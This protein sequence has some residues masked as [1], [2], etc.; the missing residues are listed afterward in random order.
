M[1]SGALFIQQ[2]VGWNLY[3]S[4]LFLLGITALCTVSG[5]DFPVHLL[6]S[7]YGNAFDEKYVSPLKKK[8]P[9]YHPF[10]KIFRRSRALFLF[11]VYGITAWPA[12]VDSIIP[13]HSI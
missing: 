11:F 6:C 4:I 1:Y 12:L 2:S 3:L 13:H 5:M 7:S 10:S 8:A 9:V